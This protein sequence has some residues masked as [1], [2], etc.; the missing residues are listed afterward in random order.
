MSRFDADTLAARAIDAA[1]ADDFG[2]DTWREGLEHLLASFESEARLSELGAGIVEGEV[3]G[4]LT[5]RLQLQGWAATHPEVA[6]VDIGAP[7]V[8]IGQARTGTTILFDLLARDPGMRAP[9]TWEVDHPVPPPSTATYDTDPRIAEVDERLAMVEVV[10][11]G[12]R[13]FHPLGATLA[14]ECVRMTALDFRSMI[15]PTQYRVPSYARWLLHEADMAS[16]YRLHRRF[17]QHLHSGHPG[18]RWLLKSPGHLWCLDALLAEHPDA[19]LVQTHRDPL[20]CIASVSALVALLRRL[21]CD[22]PTIEEAAEE[23][24][25]HILLGFDRSV[26]AR[27]DGTV[28]PARVVDVQFA[29]FMTDPFATI[30]AVYDRLG[31]ELTADAETRMRAFLA[32]HPGEAVGQ[33]YTWADTGLDAGALR[34]RARR[35]QERFEVPSEPVR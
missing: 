20:K 30:G 15:F 2:E 11:P 31:I 1:G 27:D 6:D 14:Q 32:E 29:D 17:L 7:I 12:F 24:A 9:L 5:N 13:A 3:V 21:A 8:I 25:E 35:Y 10:V 23:F 18:E 34:E 33:R 4:Y 16:A 28:D 22:D 19:V 26:A